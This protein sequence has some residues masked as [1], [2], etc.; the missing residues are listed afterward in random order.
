MAELDQD[1]VFNFYQKEKLFYQ[2]GKIIFQMNIHFSMK[3]MIFF[4]MLFMLTNE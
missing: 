1:R 2:I 4:I 3:I